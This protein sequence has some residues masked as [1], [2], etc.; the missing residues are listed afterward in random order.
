MT[1]WSYAASVRAK[2]M[3]IHSPG[4]QSIHLS[5]YPS[6]HPSIYPLYV[7][8]E[9]SFP[10]LMSPD[11]IPQEPDWTQTIAFILRNH[12]IEW[13]HENQK[14]DKLHLLPFFNSIRSNAW[15]NY[16]FPSVLSHTPLACSQRCYQFSWQFSEY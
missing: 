14:E 8:R 11:T 12:F 6:T 13:L 15:I 7:T 16:K 5:I 10:Q 1:R 2:K 4:R 9:T 3:T